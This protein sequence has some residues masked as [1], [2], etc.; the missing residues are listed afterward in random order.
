MKDREE[1][2]SELRMKISAINS[3]TDLSKQSPKF[4]KVNQLEKDKKEFED[5]MEKLQNERWS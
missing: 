1:R 4:F 3:L 5:E 2:I